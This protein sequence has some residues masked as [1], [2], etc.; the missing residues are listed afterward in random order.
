MQADGSVSRVFDGE[1][2]SVENS[3][4]VVGQDP[5]E[6]TVQF[7]I[8]PLDV[9]E[10]D[11]LVEQHLVEGHCKAAVDVVTV[12]NGHADDPANKVEVGKMIRI[13]ARVRVDLQGVDVFARVEEESVIRVEHFVT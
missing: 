2:R 13:D 1:G 7:G 10:V 3:F 11:R 4:D 5:L 8:D 6:R 9:V 12:K